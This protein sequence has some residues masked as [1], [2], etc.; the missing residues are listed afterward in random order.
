MM[1]A[2]STTNVADICLHSDLVHGKPKIVLRLESVVKG[3]AAGIPILMGGIAVSPLDQSLVVPAM[4][5]S[6]TD[7]YLLPLSGANHPAT[8]R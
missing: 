2:T 6:S 3:I 8:A 5:H 1:V 7:I 4:R